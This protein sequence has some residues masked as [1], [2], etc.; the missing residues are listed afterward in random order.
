MLD[1][2]KG[3]ERERER[4]RIE[5]ERERERLVFLKGMEVEEV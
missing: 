1:L 5:R 2:V 4:E 3:M